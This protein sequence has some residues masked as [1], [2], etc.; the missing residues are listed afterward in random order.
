MPKR[1]RHRKS[2]VD[3][4]TLVRDEVVWRIDNSAPVDLLVEEVFSTSRLLPL[5]VVSS[6]SD[7][8]RPRFSVDT[9][10]QV[11][12]DYA[13]VVVMETPQAAFALS[14]AMPDDLRVYGGATRVLWPNA[15]RN[16]H[17]NLHPLFITPTEDDGP[18][19]LRAIEDALVEAGYIQPEEGEVPDIVPPWMAPSVNAPRGKQREVDEARR[20][21][22]EASLLRERN[23]DLVSEA[24]ALRKQVR[25][26][27]DRNSELEMLLHSRR[28]Y[29]D[30]STQLEHEIWLAWL[31]SY[32]EADRGTYP[33]APYRFGPRF[34]E[35]VED[36]EGVEREK[37]VATCV[38]VLT[39]RAWEI[40]G[41]NAR[42]MR[43]NSTG[44]A[45]V[46]IRV[47][48][49]ATAWRC[50][51]QTNSPS[52]RRFMWWEVPDGFIELAVVALHDDTDFP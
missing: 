42:Q 45:S 22:A 20:L 8:G 14:E 29:A 50:N 10:V 11:T 21:R 1:K 18:A 25:G 32:P 52:A 9:L 48:D 34:V 39:R 26:L 24:A 5:I 43:T 19:T 15:T 13:N 12:G 35:S 38:D 51:I 31:H 6:P 36:I 16:D 37:V 23:T 7:T 46:R 3:T 41:R 33:L 30:P 44:G 27:S 47:H 4:N 28:V 40:N 2:T 49:Q 17:A